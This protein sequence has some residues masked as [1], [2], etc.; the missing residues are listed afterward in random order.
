MK[1]YRLYGR[2]QTGVM[3]VQAAMAE[4]GLDH[5]YVAI[6]RPRTPEETAALAAINPRLQVPVLIHPD[7]TVITEGPAILAHLADAHP[8]AGLIPAPGTSAR[9][10]HDR[11]LAFFHANVY[12]AMLRELSGHRYTID[13]AGA[14]AVQDAATAY[15]RRHFLIFEDEIGENPFL[16]GTRL[17]VFDIYLWMLCYWI[18]KGWLEANCPRITRLWRL[19]AARP[20]LAAVGAAHFGPDLP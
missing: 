14:G 17:T 10:R 2:S 12:E 3:A 16:T 4:M 7:G 8:G 19:A 6:A 18:D 5:D 15:I 1:R 13:I 9:A 11:W 20:A